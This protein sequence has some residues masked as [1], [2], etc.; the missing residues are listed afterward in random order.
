M[1]D[2]HLGSAVAN[3]RRLKNYLD[4]YIQQQKGNS[5][6]NR[7]PSR[8]EKLARAFPKHRAKVNYLRNDEGEEIT[9]PDAMAEITKQFW[10]NLFLKRN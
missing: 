5:N 2:N 10:G 1:I 3:G 6:Y 4:D 9:D 7:T 8:V